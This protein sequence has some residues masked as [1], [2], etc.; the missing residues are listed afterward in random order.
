M[1]CRAQVTEKCYNERDWIDIYGSDHAYR[2]DGTYSDRDGTVICDE[3][4]IA[5]GQPS[6][7]IDP[8]GPTKAE[9]LKH[10]DKCLVGYREKHIKKGPGSL[11]AQNVEAVEVPRVP[12]MIPPTNTYTGTVT[13]GVPTTATGTNIAVPQIGGDALTSINGVNECAT[14]VESLVFNS[15]I[16]DIDPTTRQDRGMLEG[17]Y[18]GYLRG[19]LNDAGYA[20]TSGMVRAIA[21]RAREEVAWDL[22]ELAD[23]PATRGGNDLTDVDDAPF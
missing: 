7:L 15:R 18:R 12:P 14:I 5:I 2:Q 4:Y 8:E 22:D 10:V 1:E 21:L 23:T 16:G 17:I 3:C 20:L 13:Y 9:V 6:L 19:A 11:P